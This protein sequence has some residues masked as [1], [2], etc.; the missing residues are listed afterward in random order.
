M[1]YSYNECNILSKR[2]KT[3]YNDFKVREKSPFSRKQLGSAKTLILP[4]NLL[5][6]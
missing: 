2:E 3:L 5:C 4:M 1:Y 6:L